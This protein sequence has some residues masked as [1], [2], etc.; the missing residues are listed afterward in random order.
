MKLDEEERAAA[1]SAH[2]SLTV[3]DWKMFCLADRQ[4]PWRINYCYHKKTATYHLTPKELNHDGH[5]FRIPATTLHLSTFKDVTID[6]HD[7]IRG[8]L[9]MRIA[10]PQIRQVHAHLHASHICG[11]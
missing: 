5:T 11:T 7:K 6:M 9:I 1:K 8:W 10:G 4:C 3:K 2:N